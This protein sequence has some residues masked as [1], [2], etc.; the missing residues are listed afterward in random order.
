MASLSSAASASPSTSSGAANPKAPTVPT[1]TGGPLTR[2]DAI[3]FLQRTTFGPTPEEVDELV[4]IGVDAW[5]DRQL[6]LRPVR[7][8]LSRRIERGSTLPS[9]WETFLSAPDQLRKRYAY[10]LSQIFVA[11][12]IVVGNERIANYADLLE[13]H[14]FGTYRE[15]LEHITR[16]QAMGQYLTYAGN[17]RADEYRGTVPDENYAR[18]IMQLFSIGLWEL[19]PDGTRKLD[20]DGNPIPTYSGADILGLARVFTGFSMP[21]GDLTVFT[22]PMRSDDGFSREWHEKGEKRF[23]GATIPADPARTLD[24]SV[25]AALDIVAAHPN[26]G[27]FIGRQL[28]QRLVTSNP[29]P[30]YVARVSAVFDDDG[31]GVRGNLAA[32]LRAIVTDT[33]A[34]Q[35]EPPV[36]FGKVREP[37]LRFTSVLRALRVSCTGHPWPLYSL[38]DRASELGQQPYEATSV[39][40]YYRPGYVPPRT[41]IGDAGL[42]APELQITDETTTIGWLN[43]LQA[44]LMRPPQGGNA[45]IELD[46]D[47]LLAM[48][49]DLTVTDA[50]AEAIVDE[51][52]GRLC[53]FGLDATIR[54]RIVAAVRGVSNPNLAPG[55]TNNRNQLFRERVMGAVVLV[56]ASTDFIYDR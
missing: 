13:Q 18:E 28:I 9:F 36:D 37:V 43:Y 40:N 6:A 46:I 1:Q 2:R 42:V 52:A 8:H 23:L 24:Q 45:R 35:F 17:Q 34:F 30:A 16:S 19:N 33:E 39:F 56:A 51:V 7:T 53:P 47:D 31:D 3:R 41:A 44:F 48:A 26:V 15:L 29:T 5:L 25:A 11:S 10:A 50:E 4:A 14:C 54:A 22:Q 27:P 20:G 38:A 49:P 21:Y 32:V 12:E 55:D